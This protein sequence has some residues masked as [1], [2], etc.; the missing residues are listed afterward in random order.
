MVDLAGTWRFTA[1]QGADVSTGLRSAPFLTFDGDGQVYGDA[2][3]NRV[4][5]TWELQGT[6]LVLGPMVSTMMAGPPEAMNCE[7]RILRLLGDPLE[8]VAPDGDT[9]ELDGSGGAATL[10]RDPHVGDAPV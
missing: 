7:Q 1:V 5:G 4:R 9:V 2:G 3:V 6:R 10:V 8:V